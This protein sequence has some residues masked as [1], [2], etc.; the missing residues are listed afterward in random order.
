LHLDLISFLLF[1]TVGFILGYH[2]IPDYISTQQATYSGTTMKTVAPLLM[3]AVAVQGFAPVAQR[4]GATTTSLSMGL[5]DF[6]QP[7]PKSEPNKM[8]ND[9]FAGKGKRI[10]VREDEDAAMVSYG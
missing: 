4:P 1:K 7:K 5:F 8:D 10:T 6:L 2:T 9:V 3:L